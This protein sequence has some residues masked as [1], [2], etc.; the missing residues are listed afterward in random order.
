MVLPMELGKLSSDRE[1]FAV[2]LSIWNLLQI[3]YSLVIPECGH[4]NNP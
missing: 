2:K 3:T 1:L 4:H